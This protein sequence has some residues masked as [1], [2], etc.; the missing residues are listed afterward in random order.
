MLFSANLLANGDGWAIG[1]SPEPEEMEPTVFFT[2]VEKPKKP[3]TPKKVMQFWQ[4]IIRTIIKK[5]GGESSLK[6]LDSESQ[7]TET[8][9]EKKK[10][11]K[12]KKKKRLTSFQNI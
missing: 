10:K 7:D 3:R 6:N 4:K 8:E 11:K 12:K 2:V 5:D 1:F 9:E